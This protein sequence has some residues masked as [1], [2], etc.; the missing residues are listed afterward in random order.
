MLTGRYIG[1]T[2]RPM[3]EGFVDLPLLGV[4]GFVLFLID[5]GSDYT[6]LM[7][8]DAAKLKVD[9][10]KLTEQDHSLGSGGPS[11]DYVCDAKVSFAVL[12]NTEY[13][14]D[15]RIRLPEHHAELFLAPSLLGRDVIN[16]WQLSLNPEKRTI[17][18]NVLSCNRE[19]PLG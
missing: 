18:A 4:R 14:Y 17:V 1:P 9:Y 13:Q 19:L 5:T 16:Q 15:I 11:L 12:G 2:G 10:Y 7:P 6:V 3:I 8:A